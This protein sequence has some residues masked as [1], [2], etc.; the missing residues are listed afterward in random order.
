[1]GN[2]ASGIAASSERHVTRAIP[3]NQCLS[4]GKD[5]S[6]VI[7]N[8]SVLAITLVGK[9]LFP[10]RKLEENIRKCSSVE[11]RHRYWS[12]PTSKIITER[13]PSSLRDSE[14]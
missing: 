4:L 12:K 6:S 1:M 3:G 11:N 2:V 9:V 5:Q 7:P 13:N 14:L 8:T 10:V